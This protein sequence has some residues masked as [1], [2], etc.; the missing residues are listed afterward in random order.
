MYAVGLLSCSLA[1][2]SAWAL[3]IGYGLLGFCGPAVQTPSLHLARLFEKK[4]S[5][6][7]GGSARFMS[8]QAA[9]FD[10]GSAIFAIFAYIAKATGLKSSTFFLMYCIVPVYTLLTAIFLWP[11]GILPPVDE[12]DEDEL[13]GLSSSVRSIRNHSVGEALNLQEGLA[14]PGSPL[15]AMSQRRRASLKNKKETKDENLATLKD[16][17]LR[18]VLA[19][20]AFYALASWVCS[21]IVLFLE[22]AGL[23]SIWGLNHSPFRYFAKNVSMAGGNPYPQI[24]CYRRLH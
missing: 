6:G 10:G 1:H 9:A 22:N 14:G 12:D 11:N 3:K 23:R 20:P 24:E 21:S 2:E 5:E 16:A 15:M 7:G 17:P 8:A 4:N 18:V 19:H 13:F